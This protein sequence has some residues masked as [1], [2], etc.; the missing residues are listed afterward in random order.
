MDISQ[1]LPLIAVILGFGIAIPLVSYSF[2]QNAKNAGTL[3][4]QILATAEKDAIS[5]KKEKE[6]EAR[7]ESMKIISRRKKMRSLNLW[8]FGNLRK[9]FPIERTNWITS[10]KLWIG[11][12]LKFAKWKPGLPITE[13]SRG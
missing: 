9:M 10:Q 3:A 6:L 12:K 5:I 13:R 7:D 4:E 2:K 11:K 8:K 1:F